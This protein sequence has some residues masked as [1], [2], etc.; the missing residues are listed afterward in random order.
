MRAVVLAL[1]LALVASQSVNFAPEF[2]ASKTYV[3][4]YEALVLGGLPEEGLARAGVKIIS[5]VLISAVAENTYLLK[6]VNPEIF[7][8]SG[9]WP[10]DPFVPAAKLTSALAAQFSIPIKFEYA[11]GVVGKVFAP[12]AVSETV[13]NV[14]RG[15]LNIL[16]LNIKKT[17]NV[18][19]LQEAGAQGVCK[20]HYVI[21]EDTKAERIHLTKSKDLNNC[22]E[23]IM[24]DFGLAYTE[25][26]VECQQRQKTL[27]GAAAYNYIMKPAASG[28]LIM[29]ATVTELHQFTPLNEMTGAAQMEA[30][31]MLTFVEIKNAP[32]I[33]SDA[34]YDR[35]G[36]I[37]YEFAT[38]ILQIPIQLLKISN[39]HAQ[40]V[41]ILNRLVTYDTAQVHDDAPLKFMQFIQLLR[42]ASS[43]TIEAIW[44]EFKDKPAYRHWILDAVPSIGSRVAVRFIKEK[45]LAGDI[46]IFETAQAL[47]AAVHMVAADLET[48][49][50]AESL[51]FN[52][53][54]QTH[55]VLREIA[56][57]GYGTMVSKYC[58]EN[59]NCN[60]ELVKPIHERAVEAVANS[61]FEELSM[62][63]KVLGNAGHPASIKPITKLLPVFGTAAAALPLRVQ[64]DA[65]LALRNIA[66]REPRMV[67]E[68]AVQL[69]MDKALHPELR[70]LACIVLFE[71]K[72]PMGLVTTFANILKTEENLQVA[73]FTYSHMKSLTRSTA[74]DFAS[75]A[76]AC[77]VAVK[78][79][80]TKF[81]RLSCHFSKAIHLDA[82]YSPLRI[83]AAASAFYINNAATIF[84]RTVVAK[85]R[86]YFA[87]A[88]ADVL[89]VGV[90]TEGIQEALLKIPTVT[91]NVDR[92]TKMKR[93]I[94]ALSDWRSLTTRKPLASIYVKFFGQEVAFANIDK[95]II[96]QA[97]QLANSPSARA[98]GKNA[99]KALLA[100]ATF[101]Y[102]KPLLAAEVRRI[103]P[104]AVGLPMELSFYTAAVAKAYVN[105]RATLTPP[106]PETFRI[107]QL[108]KTNI[109]LHAEVRPSIVMHTY[110][111]MG[112]NTAFIQAA[113][114]ARVKVHTIVPAKFAAKLDIANGNF[115]VE[116]FPVSA[117]EHIAAVH[118]ETFAVARNVEDVPAE[119][120]TPM[121][122][123]QGAARSAQQSREKSMMAASAASF[124]GS[125]SRSS[126]MIYSDL[127]SNFKPIIKAIAVQLED[128][129]CAERLGVKACIEYASENAD[130]IGN[131]LFY[132]M[133]GKHSVHIS[134]KP[135]ASGPAIER[136][137]FEVQVGPK[138][139]EKIIK[140]ITMNEE[141]EAPEGKTVLLKLKKLLV[142]DLKNGTRTSS[143][144]SSSHS[145]SSSSS[146]SRSRSRK[147]G[148][149]RSSSS[150]KSSSSSS[151][152][153]QPHDPIDVYDR[154]FNKNHKESEATSNVI[155]RSR[156]SASSFHA[157]YKQAKFLGNTLAPK[158][159]I[160]LRLVRADHKKEG[161]QVTAYLNKATSRL[162]IILAALDESDNWKLCADGVLLSK[163]K[164]TAKIAWGAEC[165]EYNTFITAET[166]LVGPSPAARMRLSWDRLPKVPKAV[167]HCVRILSEYIPRY[168]PS[169]LAELVPMQ[170][171]KNSEKQIQFTVVATSERT[172]DVI[173]KTPKMTLYKLGVTLPC[174][175]PIE[176]VTDLSPF[177]DNIVNKIHYVFAEVNAVKCS[178]VG[179][180]LTTFN[181]RKLEIKMPL[182][183]YQVLAQDCTIELKFMVLLKKDRASEENH[184]N[185]KISDIDVDLYPVD[186]D[187]IVK[188]NGMEIPKDDLPYQDPSASIK[189]KQKG[190]GV[191]LYAPSH[192]L[193][194]VYFDKN[195]WKIKVVDWMKGQTCGLCG[196][197]D[198]EVRQEYSTPSGRLTKS[199]VSFA[200]SWVLPSDSCRDASECL[201]TFES[202]KLE[203]QVIVDDKESKC[204]S[205][206]PV[207]RCLPGC[208]PVRTTPITIGFHCLPVDSNLSRSEGLSS[209][210]EKSVDLREKAEAHVACRCSQQCI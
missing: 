193:Q 88:A 16:Q 166:G 55:P 15:I 188:V 156:S 43:E 140:V 119:I 6:L 104:T 111:V 159:T 45:F 169:Y 168:I 2:A 113:I 37:R 149:S 158:V 118:I 38:E 19:E 102:A 134:V 50:L 12:T 81:R 208:L 54:I 5:K 167:W 128:T 64:A 194:E 123:A 34:N 13:L 147:S 11:R 107:A 185:V 95:P 67:Q 53:K 25:K 71:T 84:P 191:S 27:M 200:H 97:L 99:L 33:L 59:P 152:H 122:P 35:R 124:A 85:A 160:L 110:A 66:K 199:S 46:T 78:M 83:G 175:L 26:C 165:K 105:V 171:D 186:N 8:Y 127:T 65:V 144:S 117:P 133:I 21:S 183:C 143:S 56:M 132:N 68:V 197:A 139:A 3:Y 126:E 136:L 57:L 75:V 91:E 52:H 106:L 161:Y 103:F 77:N 86:T 28:A 10:K 189:I 145:S 162:Q 207:L 40:A 201:M 182:S 51:A 29:K 114:M 204:Y 9:V 198:G 14:H 20:T 87:G 69:F 79:L 70:M 31:Q 121:I 24:K 72:P 89:E 170:K 203:K 112:V 49:K 30:K 129:I 94:K 164:V 73:S 135:S 202:V 180:T 4:K 187:V 210:Y 130:F 196:K 7:E 172:L 157:I 39:A 109:Q 177:D 190:E 116:A 96:D 48:V 131:T 41:K 209:F 62:V 32:I 142:P 115:K 206:E 61:K 82:Y 74:P 98:L 90:R 192:G 179:D 138:A 63:L 173:L 155:S 76:A 141:E 22:Q 150:S 17:Q 80:S 93:V 120:I 146:S 151:R 23:R 154:K 58:V 100:G 163:H 42:M 205:V 184:I 153:S 181:N 137:E 174:S 36:S 101:Q 60:P 1:T 18:Y 92:I 176:S 195:S 148:S 108:L 125:L 47:V 44:A 178:M